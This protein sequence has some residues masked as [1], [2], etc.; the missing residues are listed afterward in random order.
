MA[1]G[2]VTSLTK[3]SVSF[4][5][6]C[7]E[8]CKRSWYW[9]ANNQSHSTLYKDVSVMIEKQHGERTSWKKLLYRFK[10]KRPAPLAVQTFKGQPRLTVIVLRAHVAE[11]LLF[12]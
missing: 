7:V 6:A 12:N 1:H 4:C 9:N 8:T 2:E 5:N 11:L 3:A 10:C